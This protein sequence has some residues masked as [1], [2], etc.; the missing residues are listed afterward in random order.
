MNSFNNAGYISQ[1]HNYMLSY[2]HSGWGTYGNISYGYPSVQSIGSSSSYYQ[3]QLRQPS[4]E[5]LFLA[6]KEE[7]KRDNEALQIWFPI[8]ETKMD[9][10]MIVDMGTKSKNPKREMYAIM[11]RSAIQA[12]ELEKLQKE[13]YSRQLPSD[14]KNDAK[15]ESESMSLSLKEELSSPTLDEDKNIMES[16]K[17]PLVLEGELQDLA[18]V[19]KNELAIDEE[20]S[21]K[22]KQ[23]EKQHPELIIEI[24]YRILHF[25]HG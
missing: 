6:L 19:K 11:E 4:N 15:Q 7:I 14:T 21:L 13:Q 23:V 17:M 16:D 5:E 1:P 9:T 2:N 20:Q 25:W 8:M 24:I 12:E 22:D 3:E 18:L 10:Y